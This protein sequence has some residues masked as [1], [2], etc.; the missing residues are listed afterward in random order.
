[1]PRPGDT[2]SS[3]AL[4]GGDLRPGD[5]VTAAEHGV[6]HDIGYR[7]YDGERLGRVRIRR[8]L[9]VDSLR[10]AYGLGRAGRAKVVPVLLLVVVSLPALVSVAVAAIARADELPVGYTS[11]LLN[12]QV[13][14]AVYLAAQAPV[15]VSR[16]LR[17]GVMSLYFSRPLQRIDYVLAKY[18][19]L[20][21]AVFVLLAVPLTILFVG[22]L[23]SEMPLR[24]QAPDYLRGLLTAALLAVV[25]AGL[26][27]VIA[28]MTPRRGLGVAAI[29]TV[30][31]VL[32]GV[33][34]AALAIAQ[35]QGAGDSAGWTGLLSPFTL[36][37]GVA[38]RL[39]Q[40]DSPLDPGPPGTAG[41]LVF[42]LVAVLLVAACF[43]LLVLR[44]RRVSVS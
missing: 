23:L 38:S 36:V 28:A 16:D 10:G 8:A 31:V 17:F 15:S 1:M 40:A 19:A 44:Y 41:G 32:A 34:G 39:L 9:Y 12:L 21:T 13:L 3:P 7:H 20:S 26:G 6:I 37:D 18:A 27:L 4:A 11:Y 35:E 33:Q 25:L 5:T 14:V 22:A 30:L 42:L 43:G 24:E 2:P 29:I